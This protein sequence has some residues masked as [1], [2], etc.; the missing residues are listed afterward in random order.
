MHI[1]I[2]H[3][4]HK[5]NTFANHVFNDLSGSHDTT[6]ISKHTRKTLRL[7][8]LQNGCAMCR[9]TGRHAGTIQIV[10]K[11]LQGKQHSKKLGRGRPV[12]FTADPMPTAQFHTF[13][14]QYL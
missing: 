5:H 12:D 6:S 14:L 7:V 11:Q 8:P 3:V 9:V 2:T 4:T 13:S 1:T 10:A